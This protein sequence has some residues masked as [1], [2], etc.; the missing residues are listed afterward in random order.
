MARAMKPLDSG[1]DQ[2]VPKIQELVKQSPGETQELVFTTD[3]QKLI[4]NKTS[5]VKCFKKYLAIG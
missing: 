5:K 3:Y 4:K 1:C 2:C